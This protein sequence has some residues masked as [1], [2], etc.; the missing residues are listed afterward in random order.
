MRSYRRH[1]GITFMIRPSRVLAK[2]W[3]I[4]KPKIGLKVQSNKLLTS[5]RMLDIVDRRIGKVSKLAELKNLHRGGFGRLP[6]RLF[7]LGVVH[8]SACCSNQSWTWLHVLT[9]RMTF[10][11]SYS[12]FNFII[13]FFGLLSLLFSIFKLG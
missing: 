7:R 10:R 3:F 2:F 5:S 12:I 9:F 11:V 4:D 6:G 1:Q 8:C 13:T